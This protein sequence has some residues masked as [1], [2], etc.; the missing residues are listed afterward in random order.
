MLDGERGRFVMLL[1]MSGVS[2]DLAARLLA[3]LGDLLGIPDPGTEI[4]RF[5]AIDKERTDAARHWLTLDHRYR[6]AL[7]A[8]GAHHG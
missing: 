2:R 7:D 4:A 8:L 1:R 6:A 3:G 5:D